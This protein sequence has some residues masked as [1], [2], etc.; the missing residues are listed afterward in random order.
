MKSK[1]RKLVVVVTSRRKLPTQSSVSSYVKAMS[2][3]ADMQT[4]SSITINSTLL[5]L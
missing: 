4:T 1:M 3:G 2:T 5:P